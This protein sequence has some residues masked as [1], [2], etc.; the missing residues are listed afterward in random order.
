MEAVGGVGRQEEGGEPDD[1]LG[2]VCG[3]G[4]SECTD[5]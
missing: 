2:G 1:H 5:V 3:H 4:H